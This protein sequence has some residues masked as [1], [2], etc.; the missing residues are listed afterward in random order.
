[1]AI[2]DHLNLQDIADRFGITRERVRQI[3]IQEGAPYSVILQRRRNRELAYQHLSRAWK[4]RFRTTL[5]DGRQTPE[6]RVFANMHRRCFDPNHPNFPN[7]GGRGI[8]VCEKWTGPCGYE[9]F[10]L[11]MGHRPEGLTKN[12][13]AIYSLHRIDN[14]GNYE[15]ANCKW[16]THAEQARNRRKPRLKEKA[17]GA[18]LDSASCEVETQVSVN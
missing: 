2:Y 8:T 5:P 3:L 16:A 1:M 12:G 13:R 15:P 7:Y 11:D 9:S 14:D 17:D 6:Y 18:I 4:E 10:L